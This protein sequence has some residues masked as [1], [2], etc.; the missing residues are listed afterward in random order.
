MARII[1]SFKQYSD[2][3][4]N[5]LIGGFLR[6]LVSGSNNANKATYSD[7]ARTLPNT[8]PVKLDGEGRCPN[9][10]GDGAYN[11]IS[12]DSD[13]QQ[14]EQFDPVYG[15]GAPAS[16]ISNEPAGSI[17]ATDVQ[18]AI[19]ELD[20]E[21]ARL[22]GDNAYTG[23]AQYAIGEG[24]VFN[25]DAI[26]AA[27]T[28][29]DY[30]KGTWTPSLGG[31]TS[32]SGQVY[33]AQDGAYTKVGDLVY[34]TGQITLTTLGTITGQAIIKGLPFTNNPTYDSLLSVYHG[35]M[36]TGFAQMQARIDQSGTFAKLVGR[37]TG[38]VNPT[39]ILQAHL[40]NDTSLRFSGS[41]KA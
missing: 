18:A 39:N 15:D 2:G 17:V 34:I 25:G 8:N 32:E 4:G 23:T 40:K 22:A 14:I 16:T 9:V 13:M 6:F 24:V 3:N 30:E 19:N 20:T 10:F 31:V 38:A 36:T 35:A 5:P 12:Y 26:T 21:K 41:Y 29:D 27:N 37:D 1:P 7:F 28:L 11:V 33:S